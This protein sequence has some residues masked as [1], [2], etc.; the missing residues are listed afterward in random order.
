[1]T[2][3]FLRLRLEFTFIDAVD[4]RRTLNYSELLENGS[5][6][7]DA[8]GLYGS[9]FLSEAGCYMSHE[10]VW[11]LILE[12]GQP[13]ALIC[14]DDIVFHSQQVDL[15]CFME[16]LPNHC[17]LLYLGYSNENASSFIYAACDPQRDTP[18]ACAGSH[19]IYATRGCGGTYCYIITAQ[20]AA[21]A[22]ARSRP[23]TCPVDGY[24][25]HLTADGY[26]TSC[27]VHPPLVQHTGLDSIISQY[28]Q[29]KQSR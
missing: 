6:S 25:I 26:I 12:T 2:K 5:L 1:M 7:I 9:M 28:Q 27:T 4:G 15:C 8:G 11:R 13:Y 29:E 14:E 21:K 10:N 3:E 18:V 17:E 22:L 23:I 19:R 20:G 16:Q 24:L